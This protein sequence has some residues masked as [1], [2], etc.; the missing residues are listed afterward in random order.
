MPFPSLDVIG[1]VSSGRTLDRWWELCDAN[2][3]DSE[4]P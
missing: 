1:H 2:F 4:R 3:V